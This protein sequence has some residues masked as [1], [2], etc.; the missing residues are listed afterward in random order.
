MSKSYEIIMSPPSL[1]LPPVP[2][3]PH[4]MGCVSWCKDVGKK[5]TK[6]IKKNEGRERET[7]EGEG[8]GE[9]EAWGAGK[10]EKEKKNE[11]G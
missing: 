3:L 11:G 7:K 4:F 9:E 2:N 1:S 6:T 5:I 10:R 8:R